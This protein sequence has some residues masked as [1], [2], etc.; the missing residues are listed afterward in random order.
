MAEQMSPILE[1]LSENGE[2]LDEQVHS[3]DL[4]KDT[5]TLDDIFGDLQNVENVDDANPEEGNEE[6]G[7]ACEAKNLYEGSQRCQCCINWVEEYPDDFDDNIE[8]RREYKSCALLVRHGKRHGDDKGLKIH[9]VIIQSRRLKSI[10]GDVFSEFEGITTNLQKLVFTSPFNAFFY[11]WDR[12]L[13]AAENEQDVETKKH[14]Q[15]LI[16]HLGPEIN[17]ILSVRK[18]LLDN[19][20]ITFQQLWTLFEPGTI[21]YGKL[22]GT[23]QF[24]ELNDSSYLKGDS[25]IYFKVSYSYIDY[26]GRQ[27]GYWKDE[28]LIKPFV[29]TKRVS[30]LEVYP[31]IYH[32]NYEGLKK[33]LTERGKR[34]EGFCDF[35]YK[36]Y[37]GV[38]I[39]TSW[40]VS[41]E[42]YV[43]IT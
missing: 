24:F 14:I 38:M 10:L 11:R 8:N 36:S 33:R 26:N 7:S 29:G 18:D 13:K 27:F 2:D 20:V 30:E 5:P 28:R 21:L 43:S 39:S 19:G 4:I 15:L 16:E 1:A 12:L 6:V 34:F 42:R 40:M 9:S 41:G 3:D 35:H 37:D 22:D 17:G 32:P 31:A 23:D 25:E